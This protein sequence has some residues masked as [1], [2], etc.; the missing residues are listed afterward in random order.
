MKQIFPV[1]GKRNILPPL[2][3]HRIECSHL[4][5]EYRNEGKERLGVEKNKTD[6]VRL[7]K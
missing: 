3:I 6:L 2:T 1:L 7:R 4:H 5:S